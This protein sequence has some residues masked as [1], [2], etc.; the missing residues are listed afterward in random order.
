M[1]T[2]RSP[3]AIGQH[4]KVSTGLR[5]L[6]GSEC[7]LLPRN[8]QIDSIVAGNLQEHASVRAAFIGLS[9]GMQETRAKAQAG[10]NVLTIAHGMAHGLQC[11][12][13]RTV[14]LDESQQGHVIARI[15][16]AE[17]R[18]QKASERAIGAGKLVQVGC[19]AL[20]GEKLNVAIIE[21]RGLLWEF[22]ALL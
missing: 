6:Y 9:G 2:Q 1:H 3:F 8:R 10:C 17:M 14:H 15:E 7:V 12:F 11:F 16:L 18:P 20:I 13:M 19:I 21:K 5:R 22:S 4:L